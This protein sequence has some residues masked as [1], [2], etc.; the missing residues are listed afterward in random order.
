[1]KRI[2]TCREDE[3]LQ[4]MSLREKIGQ[5][6]MA[7]F[8][9]HFD[10]ELPEGIGSLFKDRDWAVWPFSRAMHMVLQRCASLPRLQDAAAAA[11]A[12]VPLFI[13]ADQERDS[14]AGHRWDRRLP[15]QHGFCSYRDAENAYEAAE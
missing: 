2:G 12:K 5:M 3:L 14:H 13:M 6:T 10:G 4:S 9:D 8:E 11:G 1:M 7:G 15:G